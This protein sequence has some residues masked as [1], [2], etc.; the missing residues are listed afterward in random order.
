MS[1]CACAG[2]N[3][4]L[5][6]PLK[7]DLGALRVCEDILK[8][9]PRAAVTAQSDARVAFVKADAAAVVAN[10]RIGRGRECVSDVRKLYGGESVEQPKP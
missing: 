10:G 6:A 5:P 7:V 8:P 3:K 2:A 9:V 1:L 4:D